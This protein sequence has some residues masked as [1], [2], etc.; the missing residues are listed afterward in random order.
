M[1]IGVHVSFSI[2]VFSGYMPSSGIIESYGSFIPSFLRNLHTVLY[3]GCI[4][5]HSHQQCQSVPF[6]PRPLQYLLFIGFWYSHSDQC[7]VIPNCSFDWYFSSSEQCWKAFYELPSQMNVFFGELFRSSADILIALF[8]YIL[9]C[10]ILEIN[11]LLIASFANIF[12]HSVGCLELLIL[13]FSE[14]WD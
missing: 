9:S 13:M 3:S 2:I 8:F 7:E 6:S 14:L 5:L 12:A 1:N 4:N 10:Y 11:C